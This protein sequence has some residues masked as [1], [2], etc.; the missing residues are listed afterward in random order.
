MGKYEEEHT[1]IKVLRSH[2]N[3]I[4]EQVFAYK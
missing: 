1:L 3:A 2:L 4:C